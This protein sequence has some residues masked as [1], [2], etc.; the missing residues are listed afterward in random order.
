MQITFV[1]KPIVVMT[2]HG[3]GYIIYVKDSGM[4][5]NDEVCV[6]LMDGGKWMHYRTDQI[7]SHYNGI[8][9][10]TESERGTLEKLAVS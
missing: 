3:V 1:D 6:A 10:I 5:E 9:W 7:K 8:Y 4:F 2:P